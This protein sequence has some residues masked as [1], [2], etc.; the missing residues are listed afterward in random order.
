MTG[1]GH[2]GAPLSEG[3]IA[4]HRAVRDHW[5]VGHGLHVKPADPTRKRCSTQGE[6]W[7][8]L[9][10][11]CRYSD[12]TVMNGGRK[13]ELRRGELI[14]AVSW[15]GARWNWTPKT[16]RRFLDQLEADGMIELKSP[17][18]QNGTQ[19]GKQSTVITVCNYELY[20]SMRGYDG[21]AKEQATGEQRASTGQAEGTQGARK[22]QA[23][24]NIYKEEQR[25]KGTREP[26]SAWGK[27]ER[28]EAEIAEA[29]RIA[30]EAYAEGQRIKG[31]SVAKSARSAV[32]TTGELDGSRGIAFQ[33]GKLAIVNGTAA[34]FAEEF[35]GLDILAV[36]NKAGPE[37]A[38]QSYPTYEF[39]CSVVRK[40]AQIQIENKKAE[41]TTRAGKR[42]TVD[43]S[44]ALAARFRNGGA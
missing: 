42:T 30:A 10:M 39:A 23:E 7:E 17:G 12:G 25:N 15:L 13:M 8:D 32:V 34:M 43:V 6:A 37:I 29:D 24:G 38:R 18:V 3:W 40:W 35:P 44:S 14:G 33:D 2:N 4:R 22:G 36:C 16:V 28:T 11:E 27:R 26:E 20:Q 21:Q 9:C 5:L 1:I 19:K 31:A 41:P